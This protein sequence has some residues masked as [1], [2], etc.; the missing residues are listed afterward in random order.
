MHPDAQTLARGIVQAKVQQGLTGVVV[1]LAAGDDAKPVVR[2]LNHI[3]VEFVG[4]DIR[5]SGIPF[6]IE[7]A[8]FLIK[9][10]VWPSNVDAACWHVEFRQDNFDAVRIDLRGGTGLHNFL[11]RFHARPD[12]G[13]AAQRDA[14][15]AHVQDILDRSGEENRQPAGLENMVTLVCGGR[16][17]GH[18]VVSGHRQHAAPRRGTCHVGMLEYIRAAVHTRAFAVPNAKHTV[19]TVAASRRKA[20]LLSPP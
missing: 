7:Q 16:A 17:F 13:K 11:N 18:M 20:K 2:P 14:V 8:S 12:A 19:K 10:R 3:V 6:V 9:G 15:D 1:G 4:A 5:Q